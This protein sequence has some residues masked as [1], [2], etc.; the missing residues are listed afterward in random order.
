M[1][2]ANLEMSGFHNF[3]PIEIPGSVLRFMPMSQAVGFQSVRGNDLS[4][5]H[6]SEVDIPLMK[7]TSSRLFV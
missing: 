6:D 4:L 5:V 2:Q 1:C 3:D 7:I